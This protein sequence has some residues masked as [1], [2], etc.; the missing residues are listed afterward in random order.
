VVTVSA[1]A[2]KNS[3]AK[4]TPRLASSVNF[5]GIFKHR[6]ETV[7]VH[8]GSGETKNGEFFR[9]QTLFRKSQ[10]CGR[11]FSPHQVTRCAKDDQKLRLQIH[12]I[13]PACGFFNCMPNCVPENLTADENGCLS[14]NA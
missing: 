8:F 11:Q 5:E 3:L 2:V 1:S 10:K 12:P 7:I 6:F 4:P 9:K 13:H 14:S